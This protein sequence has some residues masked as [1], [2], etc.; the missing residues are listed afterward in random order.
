MEPR[1]ALWY[2][3]VFTVAFAVEAAAFQGMTNAGS[4]TEEEEDRAEGLE[5]NSKDVH[6]VCNRRRD[7]FHLAF[8]AD[9]RVGRLV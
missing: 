2:P 4:Q 1:A 6:V 9:V 7:L 3:P 8:T 5:E